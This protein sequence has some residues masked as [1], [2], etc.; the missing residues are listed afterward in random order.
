M[1]VMSK[2]AINLQTRTVDGVSIRFAESEPRDDHPL[3]TSPWP[4]SNGGYATVERRS[5]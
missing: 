4:E 3:L 2:Q 1:T 5:P